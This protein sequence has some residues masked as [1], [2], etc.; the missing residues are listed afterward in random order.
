M[1]FIIALKESQRI[2]NYNQIAFLFQSVKN[3]HAVKLASFLEENHINVYSPRSD[4]FFAREE[5]RLALG[6]MMLLFPNYVIGLEN[7]EYPFLQPRHS[8]YYKECVEAANAYLRKQ[9]NK[10]LR[11]WIKNHGRVHTGL[12]GTT[13]YA[14][15]GLLYQMFEYSP[16]REI[17]ATDMMAGVVD[18]RPQ[19]IL[20]CFHKLLVSTSICIGLRC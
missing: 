6:V 5:I 7:D 13:D 10:E 20:L 15:S 17:L 3:E 1:D 19:G 9:E 2:S 8:K 16:F 14:Y 18:V 4:M 12:T 11:R